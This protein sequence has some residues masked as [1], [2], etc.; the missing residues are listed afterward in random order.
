MSMISGSL[1]FQNV[2]TAD[3]W[4]RTFYRG[5]G[6]TISGLLWTDD[7]PVTSVLVGFKN[8][9][10]AHEDIVGMYCASWSVPENIKRSA[11]IKKTR[12]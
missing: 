5:S 7:V 11:Y 6:S 8:G 3:S 9:V 1:N 12:E 10:A 2:E 4:C